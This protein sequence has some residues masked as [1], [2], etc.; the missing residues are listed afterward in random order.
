MICGGY[1]LI[2]ENKKR[3][4]VKN[5]KERDFSLEYTAPHLLKVNDYKIQ[6]NIWGEMIKTLVAYLL[7]SNKRSVED[8]VGF[9]TK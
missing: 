9:K 2:L 7:M 8:V 5:L 3:Y 6:E 4:Y 1:E